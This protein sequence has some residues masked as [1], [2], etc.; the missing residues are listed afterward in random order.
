VIPLALRGAFTTGDVRLVIAYSDRFLLGSGG[1]I[2]E[3]D[4]SAFGPQRSVDATKK[5]QLGG[6]RQMMNRQ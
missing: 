1:D 4:V 2:I 6:P 5:R 3:F